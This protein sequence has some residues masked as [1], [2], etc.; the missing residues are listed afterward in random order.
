[1][2]KM[3]LI[4]IGKMGKFHLNLYD[5]ISDI[6]LTALCDAD[7]DAVAEIAEKKGIPGFTDYK[8]MFPYVDAV[9]IAAPT[10]YH[11]DIAKEC[12][13]A[14]KHVLVEKP[15]TTNYDQAVELF[16]IAVQKGLILHIGHV[17]RF[18]GA[19]QELK[20]IVNEPYVVEARRVG[21]FNPGFRNDSIVL[22]LMIH[23]IDIIVNLIHR[24]VQ[25][26]QVMGAPVYTNL[27]DYASV[28]ISFGTDTTARIYV[29]RINQNK[30]R[31]LKITQK[32]ALIILDYT[33]QDINII[34]QG[35]TQH[36]FGDKELKYKNEFIQERLFV[37]KENPLKMEIRHFVACVKGDEKRIV[38]V[39]HDLISLKVALA[40]DE[41][42]QKSCH[43]SIEF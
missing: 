26:V 22:D 37:Y 29:S 41:L 20:K 6:G 42:L 18:N 2:V 30:E 34:R 24:P 4:G 9:T 13:D 38:S 14:G 36:I 32:D 19:V 7:A 15:I 23:D 8:D 5:E 40:V 31:F 21:P 16:N 28:N 33:N 39:E 43:G 17:E 12:L 25:A 35:Q 11:F 1:M 10:K 3:G 27:A